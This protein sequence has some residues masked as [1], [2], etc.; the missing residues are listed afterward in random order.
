[1][2]ASVYRTFRGSLLPEPEG[3]IQFP[4][5]TEGSLSVTGP[6]AAVCS[7]L[8]LAHGLPRYLYTQM[9]RQWNDN[10][11]SHTATKNVW[12]HT[13]IPP[14]DVQ[15]WDLVT[16]SVKLT[17][18][19]PIDT[20]GTVNIGIQC[21]AFDCLCSQNTQSHFQRNKRSN[22]IQIDNSALN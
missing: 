20:A 11:R 15:A 4:E 1:M 2:A 12:F 19:V 5:G 3:V 14:C 6:G 22:K 9:K 7:T 13:Y 17:F 8:P 21:S 18:P 16:A 10:S